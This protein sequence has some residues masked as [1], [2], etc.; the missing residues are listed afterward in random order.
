MFIN[1]DI[2]KINQT[3]RDFFNATGINIDLLKD[4]F[5]FVVNHSFW[6]NKRYCRAIQSTNKGKKACHCSDTELFLKSQKSKKPQ[7]H[8]CHAGLVDISL[9]ILY[10]DVIIGYIIFGQMKTDTDFS[11]LKD[12]VVKLGL[13]ENEMEK[14]YSEIS[15]F[16]ADKIQS[17]SNLAEIL[18]K[19]I[20][21]ENMLKPNLDDGTKRAVNYIHENLASD[22]TIQDIEK[23]A[24]LSKSVLYRRFHSCFGCTVS[25]YI[26]KQRIEKSIVLLENSNMSI[27]DI[28]QK[29]GFTSGSYFSKRFKHEKGVS[30]FKFKQQQK[31]TVNS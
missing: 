9:P 5:T 16:D 24:N 31:N 26:N 1:Y 27:E 3:F 7:M 12:Y 22:I 10:N 25:Q 30:P 28:A 20:L 4:D 11:T 19:H 13:S 8:I 6:E 2:Q 29:V 17:V 15:S 21:L 18:V 23:N 14:Y